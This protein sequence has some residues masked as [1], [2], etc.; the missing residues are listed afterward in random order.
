V[1]RAE[2][3]RR[4]ALSGWALDGSFAHNLVIGYSGDEISVLAHREAWGDEDPNFVILDL[5]HVR[6][7]SHWVQGVPT[8][9]QARKLLREHSKYAEERDPN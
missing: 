8:P 9:E 4:F 5:D 1:S 3:E 2:I 6:I 7:V